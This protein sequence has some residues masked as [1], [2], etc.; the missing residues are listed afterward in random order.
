MKELI[1]PP[2]LWYSIT[3]HDSRNRMIRV[4]T[5]FRDSKVFTVR[6]VKDVPIDQRITEK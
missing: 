3:K 5:Y 6:Y 4:T 2:K 1:P